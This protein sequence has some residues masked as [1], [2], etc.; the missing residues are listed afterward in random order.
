MKRIVSLAG[1]TLVMASLTGCPSSAN[2]HTDYDHNANFSQLHTFS[3]GNVATDDPLYQQRIK[4]E[5]SKDL[6]AKGLQQAQGKGDLV[7]TAVGAVHNR[8]E[9]QTF[10]NDPGFGYYWGGFGTGFDNTTTSVVHYKVGTLVLDMY[11]A[12]TKHLVWRGTASRGV[13]G[14]PDTNTASVDGA[15][16]KMLS[17]FPPS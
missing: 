17:S 10:Y 15:I 8:K 14:N 7:V 4:D 2:I 9:Y 1:V 5:I 16:D 3:F 12:Q 13:S 6:E 11:N